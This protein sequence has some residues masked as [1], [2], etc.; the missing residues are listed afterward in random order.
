MSWKTRTIKTV[1]ILGLIA[2]AMVALVVG[3]LLLQP[4]RDRVLAIA[5][6]MAKRALPGD[7]E[8]GS[9]A[10]PAP[11]SLEFE[12]ILWTDGPDTL[13]AAGHLRVAVKLTAVVRHD[14]HL[15][16]I[17]VD[18]ALADVP[19]IAARFQSTA[20]TEKEAGG[21]GFLRAGALPGVPSMAVD[22]VE[23]DARRVRVSDAVD[24]VGIEIRGAADLLHG[25]VPRLDIRH[26]TVAERSS[27]IAADSLRFSADLS[28]FEIDGD[29][30]VR[31]PD[32]IALYLDGHSTPDHTFA[33][34]LTTARGVDPPDAD[35]IALTGRADI[36]DRRPRSVEVTARFCTPGTDA[37][38]RVPALSR[39]LDRIADL[40]GV[41][42]AAKGAAQWEPNFSFDATVDLYRSSW[43][44]TAHVTVAYENQTISIDTVQ[45]GMPGL[46][47]AASGRVP[48]KGGSATA[49]V[50]LTDSEWL[51]R[52]V[53]ELS[54]PDS[55]SAA[56]TVEADGLVGVAATDVRLHGTASA[57]G[58][59]LD[60]LVVSARAPRESKRPYA[61]DLLVGT[62]GTTLATHAEIQMSP[63]VVVRLTDPGGG[64]G[65]AGNR[66]TGDV[67]YDP[68]ARSVRVAGVRLAGSLGDY[69]VDAELDS[70]QRGPVRAVCEWSAP[71]AA[72]FSRLSADSAARATIDSTWTADGPFAV[73]IDG[74]LDRRNNA[75]AISATAAL[76]LPGPRDVAPLLGR[77]ASVGDLG[78][79][80][81]RL[82][83]E[84]G[85]C[86]DGQSYAA[87]LDL[88]Q[89][90]WMDTALASVR[91]CG[92]DVEI[93]TLLVSF[94]SLRLAAEGGKIDSRWDLGA[95]LALA[96]S[97]LIARFLP[98][99]GAPSVAL[100]ARARLTGP[101]D[102]PDVAA[103]WSASFAS[104]DLLIPRLRG[105]VHLLGDS[106]QA[107]VTTP[108]GVLGYGVSL[109][110]VEVAHR[111]RVGGVLS[112]ATSIRAA[113]P[114]TSVLFDAH[115]E[116]DGG[117]S[118]RADT[119]YWA[120][121]DEY[122]ASRRPFEIT[123]SPDGMLRVADLA[124]GG[125]LGRVTAD[126]YTSPDS[127]D[128]SADV[129]FHPPRKP[130]FLQIADR[131]WPDSLSL[132]ARIDGPSVYRVEG[133]IDGVALAEELPVEARYAAQSDTAGT[134]SR[135]IL[136]S[137]QGRLLEVEAR[138]PA[139]RIGGV[140]ED[141][142]V[143]VDVRLDRLPVPASRRALLAEKPEALAHIDGRIA[144]RGMLSDPSAV[145]SLQM[146]FTGAGG[147]EL[148][149]YQ[150]VIDA[151]LN[152]AAATDT[153][154]VRIRR[155]RFRTPLGEQEATTGMEARLYITKG[156][157]DVLT[158]EISYPISL[159]IVPVRFLVKGDEDVR[160]HFEGKNIALT[161]FDPL[162]PPDTDLEGTCSIE[163]S[164]SGPAKNAKLRGDVR[165]QH[166]Q[167]VSAEGAEISP[168]IELELGGSWRR[169]SIGGTVRIRS[170]F[171]RVP[172]RK[173]QLYPA[174]GESDLWE[175]AD[176]AGAVRDTTKTPSVAEAGEGTGK[177][178]ESGLD[179]DIRVV[180][181]GSFRIV[182]SRM[183]VELS[184]DLQLVQ[185]NDRPVLTGQLT[186]LGGQLLFMGRTFELRRGNVYF[187]GG[188]ELN[189]SFD[190]TLV[191]EVSGYRI[192][193]KLTG[194]MKDPQIE[195]TSD[196][197][198][199]E[200]DIMSLLVFGKP[201]TE[202]NSSQ[203]G[204]LQQRTA[205]MLMVY[206]AVKLQ[207][208]MS[209][210]MGVD[211]I[212]VQ[213]STR[214]PDETALV[215]GKYLNSRTLLKYE[216]NL[217]NTAAYLINLEYYL[218]WGIKIETFIDQASQT[219]VEINRSW[220]Y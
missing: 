150:L 172:E 133:A 162:L 195:L 52:V 131:L 77:G 99:A 180:I 76:R 61:V 108:Q 110:S 12:G 124:L 106:L 54:L 146:I 181:P 64:N 201:M 82:E 205:E 174:E 5:L 203:S 60:T 67:R 155:E 46:S 194:T 45:I 193:I 44:D 42:G 189:P 129:I 160:V 153:A 66:L 91:G 186:P 132:N 96:D 117:F 184:G 33:V 215:V 112:G 50:R 104:K 127:A 68:V 137:S 103:D 130:G 202:L 152:R 1:R 185:K 163:L 182:G 65:G 213:Q 35:G 58:A 149:K 36:V 63:Q 136:D 80:E 212:T 219:G 196:P 15:E 3:L 84:T 177:F 217:Q 102:A 144:V 94:D 26:L 53:P 123:M 87:S 16:E 49:V 30:T 121:V 98:E 192:E 191:S 20:G 75:R 135:F 107:V 69:T 14:L 18:G 171:I 197:Q 138:L 143:F 120:V 183:N 154:L 92:A 156:N 125:S 8:I 145:A 83:L 73:R 140:P 34:R 111:G 88:G 70:L 90:A 216:Q 19:A 89:T 170:G 51:T 109:D 179:L 206:G 29:G 119:L 147:V 126:G 151:T 114:E 28:R 118:M 175:A 207:E 122:L 31:L 11:G 55:L 161:D 166:A 38:A 13:A 100:D 148:S 128:F 116:K 56:L 43:L 208:E 48:P 24:L 198:L 62:A 139:Y 17:A 157:T 214:N 32:G 59:V 41:C 74:K 72:L 21:G 78:P 169:P 86:V 141:G 101:S 6:P 23:I 204:W 25:D 93:D 134:R 200:G 188:D 10:W 71:P 165:T 39:P 37:L 113:G 115:W 218:R 4:V 211:I 27:G 210:Q 190:L 159:S 220:D 209:Q 167:I 95:T 97:A 47:L 158:G 178:A 7:L 22:R 168:D 176:S 199:A 105:T 2:A 40:E 79:V 142:P 57:D 173:A 85:P 9:A 81:G 164:A 187:Y